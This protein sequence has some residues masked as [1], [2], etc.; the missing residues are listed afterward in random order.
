MRISEDLTPEHER[1]LTDYLRGESRLSRTQWARLRAAVDL[2][3]ESTVAFQGSDYTFTQFYDEFIDR[4]FSDPFLEALETTRELAQEAP[5]LRA[6]NAR[7]IVQWVQGQAFYGA[8]QVGGRLLLTFCLYWWSAFALGYTFELEVF[9]DLQAAGVEF[10]CHDITSR[11]ERVS[12]FDLT[13][14]GLRGDVKYS[15]YFLTAETVPAEGIDFFVTRLYDEAGTRWLTAVFLTPVAWAEIDGET[16]PVALA[17]A[18]SILPEPVSLTV[19][20]ATFVL[21]LYDDWK[22][23]VKTRQQAEGDTP[24]GG[25]NDQ[26]DEE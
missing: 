26:P 17:D 15:T 5:R 7:R 14:L 20:D 4:Q 16:T 8:E 13:V 18:A 19:A 24:N 22:A 10:A 23:R 12:A 25:Q 2:L 6:E 21:V 9:R 1:V 11:A 3:A